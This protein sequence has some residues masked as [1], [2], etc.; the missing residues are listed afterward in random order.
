MTVVP[1]HYVETI[2]R[3]GLIMEEEILRYRHKGAR[4]DDL[5]IRRA[6]EGTI[7]VTCELCRSPDGRFV[8]LQW[9][10]AFTQK[11]ILT[12]FYEANMR[13]TKSRA[14]KDLQ[15]GAARMNK[16]TMQTK[17]AVLGS[18]GWNGLMWAGEDTID[19]CAVKKRRMDAP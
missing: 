6:P 16:F 9:K 17:F 19:G 1:F 8:A 4:F 7:V 11:P 12:K 18:M 14:V 15:E 13:V 3:P 2:L 10:H 5:L